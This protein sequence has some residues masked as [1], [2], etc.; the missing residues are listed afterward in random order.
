MLSCAI[1]AAPSAF[2]HVLPSAWSNCQWVLIRCLI[3]SRLRLLA[4]SADVNG[5]L[6]VEVGCHRREIVGIMIHVVP[7]SGLRRAAV[8]APIMGDNAEAFAEEEKHLRVPIVRRERP[9]MT[10]HDRVSAAPIFVID[11]DVCSVFFSNSYVW[12]DGLSFL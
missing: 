3:G 4:A 9:A 7:V 8:S 10:E 6:E 5:V 1:M 11:L 2:S 12:H